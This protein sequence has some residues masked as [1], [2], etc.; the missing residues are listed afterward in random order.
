[1]S[2]LHL[3]LCSLQYKRN[4]RHDKSSNDVTSTVIHF[5]RLSEDDRRYNS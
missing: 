2:V 3:I 1:M 5:T 4:S